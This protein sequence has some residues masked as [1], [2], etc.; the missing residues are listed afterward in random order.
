VTFPAPHSRRARRLPAAQV[1]AAIFALAQPLAVSFAAEVTLSANVVG[2]TP[3]RV[4]YNSG[5]FMAGSNTKAWWDY[6]NAN[7]ARVWS[8]PRTVE[9]DDD[10]SVW[11]DRV[12][13]E[14]EFISR[15][16]ALRADPENTTFINWPYLENRYQNNPTTGSNNVNLKYAFQSLHEL[17]VDPVIE[18]HRSSG[19]YPFDPAGTSAGWGDRW[20]QWQHFYAQAFYL[21]KNFDVRRFQMYNEPNHSSNTISQTEYIERLR[22]SS[23]AVQSAVA[24][25]NQIYGKSL[26]VQMHA[27]VTAGGSGHFN[28]RPGG[29]TRDDL[30]GWGE[31]VMQNLHTNYL[32]QTD[33]SFQLIDTYAVQ[34]YNMD[35]PAFANEMRMVKNLVNG[36][37]GGAPVRFAIT[38]FGVHTAA[39]FED[40]TETMDSPAKFTTLGSILSNL[41]NTQVEELYLQKFSL[42]EDDSVSGVKKNGLHYVDNDVTP[43]DIGDTTKGGEVSRLFNK[44][45]AGA[46]ELIAKP[47]ATG[48]GASSLQLAAAHAAQAG[49]YSLFS[50]NVASTSAAVNLNVS[51][52]GIAPGTIVTV[53]EVSSE[54][55]GEVRQLIQTPASGQISL[56]QP[57]QSVFLI[58]VPEMA[59]GYRVT[60]GATDD[61]NVKAGLSGGN[62][63]G[64]SPNLYAKN[65]PTNP[66]ARNVTFIKFDLGALDSA[67]VEQAVLRV[68]GEDDGSDPLA[69]VIA[70]VYGIAGDAW[71]ESTITWD[72]A[73]NL[74]AST[75]TVDSIDDNFIEGVGTTAAVLGHFTGT[76]TG[77]EMLLDVTSFVR[78]HADQQL[79]FMIAREV[80]FNGENV[81]D[82]LTSLKLASKERGTDSGPQ[83]LLSLDELALPGD[84]NGDGVVDGGDL[85]AWRTGLGMDSNATRSDGDADRDGDVDGQDYLAWQRHLGAN[86]MV[87]VASSASS[88]PEPGAGILVACCVGFGWRLR[89]RR[90]VACPLA[91]HWCNEATVLGSSGNLMGSRSLG[92]HA[93]WNS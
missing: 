80:R 3:E 56:T 12:T 11:G 33:P 79:T 5:H 67:H 15:R 51:N 74:A 7:A 48:A 29:D 39:V 37:A 25:V 58:T 36:A 6:S 43:Y 55:H 22:L 92:A 65:E 9:G 53:E 89:R 75:G 19:A 45:F 78:D 62:N 70:H 86:L 4:G 57:G 82:D 71:D 2:A 24:D 23:D 34:L 87:G 50:S 54:R 84:F 44:G 81:I 66:E 72:N 18:M 83:L 77:R 59:P 90:A 63:Y 60:L 35:G 91:R 85:V 13:S 93:L 52:W 14:Q 32:G 68:F 10:N 26:D 27:P 69:H 30:V 73:P 76:P 20:E 46:H 42:T 17:G 47:T 21:A 61:A 49:H 41:A 1:A 31:L 38:E 88:V 40:T 64:A 8:T 28:E 16:S